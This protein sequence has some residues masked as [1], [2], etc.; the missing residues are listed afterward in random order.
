MG[1]MLRQT[2]LLT[3]MGLHNLR[4]RRSAAIVTIVSVTTAVGVLVSL[5]AIRE[6]TNI[7]RPGSARTDEAGVLSRGATSSIDSALSREDFASIMEAPGV[8]KSADGRPYAYASTVVSVD[9]LRRSGERGTVNLVG[10]TDGWQRVDA[11]IRVMAGRL[12][13]PA[14]HE[15]IVSEPIHK[16][17]LG[18]DIGDHIT[19]RG[20]QWTVVGIFTSG[21]SLADSALL[22]DAE[23]V[24]SAFGRNTLSQVNVMLESPAS[25][26]VFTDSLDH[27]PAVTVEV[28][29]VAEQYEQN[30]S[31][32]RRV[33][34]FI[35]YFI[36]GVMAGGAA[37]AALNSMYVAVD[38]RRRETATLRA[39]GFNSFP[40]IT[41]VLIESTLLAL[42][43]AIL[44]TLIAWLLFNGQAVSTNSLV[45]KLRVTPHLLFLA[46]GWGLA[47]GLVGGLLPAL[48][49]ARRPVATAMRAS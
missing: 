8:K 34:A 6:G 49:A 48:R 36:G 35:S 38:S 37:C 13:R 47:I 44:G 42:P 41:A 14:L 45:F 33:L 11:G 32:L 23:T 22:A 16:M 3:L 39:V 28:K 2:A 46:I 20:T 30:F 43:G 5:L 31:G 25:F 40:I 27:N 12:N 4:Q 26:K 10:Y 21:D 19:L 7:L 24:M 9:A 18:F 15:L 17:F 29:T 1:S